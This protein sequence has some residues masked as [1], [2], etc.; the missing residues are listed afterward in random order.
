MFTLVF[1]LIF[2]LSMDE[3]ILNAAKQ[4]GDI[5]QADEFNFTVNEALQVITL[6]SVA[7]V[8]SVEDSFPDSQVR[9]RL[10]L[11]LILDKFN[12]A[13]EQ[14]KEVSSETEGMGLVP[15]ES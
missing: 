6:S 13:K 7:F 9:D 15:S 1:P 10:M 12:E 4:I 2:F 14:T 3:K 8:R 11:S 5:L